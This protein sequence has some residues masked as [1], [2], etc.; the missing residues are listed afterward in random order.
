MNLK[1]INLINESSDTLIFDAHEISIP[2]EFF[3][4]PTLWCRQGSFCIIPEAVLMN[5]LDNAEDYAAM[6]SDKTINPKLQIMWSQGIP[7]SNL[8][9][10]ALIGE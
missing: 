9:G 7:I 1:Q 4:G 3:F 5:L 10:R 8:A 6:D 2:G